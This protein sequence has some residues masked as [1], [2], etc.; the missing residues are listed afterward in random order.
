VKWSPRRDG[1][2][3]TSCVECFIDDVHANDL[4]LWFDEYGLNAVNDDERNL[5]E[6]LLDASLSKGVGGAA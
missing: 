1:G 6:A 5:S 3:D 4:A 2:G